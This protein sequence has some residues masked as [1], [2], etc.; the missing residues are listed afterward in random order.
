MNWFFILCVSATVNLVVFMTSAQSEMFIFPKDGQSAEQQELDEFSCY[1]WAKGQTGFD[2]N[3]QVAQ[4]SAPKR[5]R[6]GAS[7]GPWE[8]PRWEPL[9]ERLAG[10]PAKERRLEP[11]SEVQEV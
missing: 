1:K 3:Q 9:E 10:M 7:E 2:P 6:G 11:R 8:A 5:Q 4:T